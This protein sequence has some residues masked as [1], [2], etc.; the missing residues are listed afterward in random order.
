MLVIGHP[1][2][3]INVVFEQID[4]MMVLRSTLGVPAVNNRMLSVF[5]DPYCYSKYEKWYRQQ[6][7]Q[8]HEDG[9]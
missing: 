3:D 7:E 6:K 5:D 2:A 8:Q 9:P 1:S 4:E